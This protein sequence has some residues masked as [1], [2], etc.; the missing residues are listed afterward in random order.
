[1]S[2]GKKTVGIFLG[3]A[4]FPLLSPDVIYP[5]VT[6]TNAVVSPASKFEVRKSQEMRS[7]EFK[8]Y[9]EQPLGRMS[10]E[11]ILKVSKWVE[12]PKIPHL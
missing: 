9:L 10:M 11:G 7:E 12:N 2:D 3:T 8:S 6:V 4:S 1:M 5:R